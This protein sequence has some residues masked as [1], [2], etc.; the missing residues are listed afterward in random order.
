MLTQTVGSPGA[1]RACTLDAPQ[2]WYHSLSKG[3]LNAL[4][5]GIPKEYE[6]AIRAYY[7]SLSEK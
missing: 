4:D 2:A 1:W 6:D 5:E 3:I 7:K